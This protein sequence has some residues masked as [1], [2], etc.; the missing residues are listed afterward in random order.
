MLALA[1]TDCQTHGPCLLASELSFL[2][3]PD[4]RPARLTVAL[5]LA[6]THPKFVAAL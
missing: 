4:F 5:T 6:L 1:G 2:V 3:R